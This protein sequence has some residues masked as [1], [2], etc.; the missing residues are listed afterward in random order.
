V[1]AL[2]RRLVRTGFRR[3]MSGSQTWLVLAI[4]ALGV[5]LLRKLANPEPEL[6]YSAEVKQGDRFEISASPDRARKL[7]RRRRLT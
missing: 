7:R 5:R 2:L 1:D 4:S 3:G 6:V